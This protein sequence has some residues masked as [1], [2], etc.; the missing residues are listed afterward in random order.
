MKPHTFL[1]EQD[2]YREHLKRI[3]TLMSSRNPKLKELHQDQNKIKEM[4]NRSHRLHKSSKD[5]QL[6]RQQ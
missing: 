1:I 5:F 4:M 6:K 2:K 3:Q